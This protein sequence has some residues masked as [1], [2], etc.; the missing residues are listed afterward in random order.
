MSPQVI[1]AIS[2]NFHELETWHIEIIS[3]TIYTAIFLIQPFSD[4]ECTFILNMGYRLIVVLK[5]D[6]LIL[7]PRG[8]IN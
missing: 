7:D 6:V 3:N 4:N 2:Q 1:D 5:N 8:Y